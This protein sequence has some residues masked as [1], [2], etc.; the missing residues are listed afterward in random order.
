MLSNRYFL[1]TGEWYNEIGGLCALRPTDRLL[2]PLPLNHANAMA[3]STMAMVRIGG[4]LIVLDRFHPRT[5]WH[6]VRESRATIIHYLGVMPSMLMA[7]PDP[8]E[9]EHLVR[10]GFGAGVDRRLHEAAEQ[11]FG[12]PLIE[13]WAMTETGGGAATIV[14]R[15]PRHLG[16][17]CIGR[18]EPF[19][20]ARIIDDSGA[21]CPAGTPGEFLVR[22]A[23]PDPRAGFFTEYLKDPEATASA[24][25]GGWF[26]TG[27]VVRADADGFLYFVDRKKNIVR[28]SGENIAAAEVESVL[29]RHQLIAEV[30]VAAV[31]DAMRGRGGSRLHRAAHARRARAEG[32]GGRGDRAR[33]A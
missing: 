33:G 1:R 27:D 19:M 24:W 17:A 32:G 15:A 7:S 28:R 12:F 26:H 8:R 4:C 3:Y 23:G 5:W 9:R 18:A 29:R 31:P 22:A 30:A 10:F 13:A 21:E 16:E 14:S 11:R 25:A 6:S 20:K 2:T